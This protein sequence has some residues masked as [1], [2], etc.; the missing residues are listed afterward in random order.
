MGESGIVCM[1]AYF[2]AVEG[3]RFKLCGGRHL[4]SPAAIGAK[5]GLVMV[6]LKHS[7]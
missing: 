1:A 4:N 2:K 5:P 7:G 3:R 6:M